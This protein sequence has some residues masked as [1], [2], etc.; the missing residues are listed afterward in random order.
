[1][2]V[3]GWL[4]GWVIAS[5]AAPFIE[6]WSA[7]MLGAL[8]GII[9]PLMMYVIDRLLRLDDATAAVSVYGVPGLLGALAVGI[10][11]DGRWGAGWNGVGAQEYLLVAGQGV[12][13][14]LA[15]AG[16]APDSGQLTAQL[17]SVGAIA[18]FALVIGW[19]MMA[20]ANLVVGVWGSAGRRTNDEGR[21]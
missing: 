2:A 4:A 14:F 11:A 9:L 12:T 8:A 6:S 15:A 16:F 5:A 7:L 17:A 3:R 10:L 21:T 18:G 19:V 13:G 1:M 20:A